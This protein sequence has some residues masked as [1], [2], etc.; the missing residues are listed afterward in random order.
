MATTILQGNRV[1]EVNTPTTIAK[2]TCLD[3][4]KNLWDN[5]VINCNTTTANIEV[6]LP[7]LASLGNSL[8]CEII[9]NKVDASANLVK[10]VGYL[11]PLVPSTQ[12]FIGSTASAIPLDTQWQSAILRPVSTSSWAIEYSA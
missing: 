2:P 8:N 5:V 11:D 10:I 4:N 12:E 3:N 6:K 7:S 9:I 1:F